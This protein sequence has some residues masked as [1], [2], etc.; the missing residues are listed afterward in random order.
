[1]KSASRIWR[2]VKNDTVVDLERS[3]RLQL[4]EGWWMVRWF[5]GG[6]EVPARTWLCSHE[7]GNPA[8]VL[9]R[10][11]YWRAQVA[12]QEVDPL[13]ILRC[14]DVRRVPRREVEFQLA[15]LDYAADHEPNN[16]KLRPKRRVDFN[17][18]PLPF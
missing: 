10:Q 11:P 3:G 8:N 9:D 15:D 2:E 18:A 16:P 5:R 6:P 1:M 14:R 7:P 4:V 17:N 13:D 12:G